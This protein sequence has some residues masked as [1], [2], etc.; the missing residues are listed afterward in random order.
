MTTVSN[1]TATRNASRTPASSA[2]VAD[3]L[4][5]HHMLGR[6]ARGTEV[7][8]LQNL[9]KQNGID[10]GP[11]D[12]IFGPKTQAAVRQFQQKKGLQVDGKVGQQTWAAL[13]G[14]SAA[15]GTSML[16]KSAP[17]GS[18]DGVDAPR[19]KSTSTSGSSGT[20]GGVPPDLKK[21]GNGRIPRSALS[22]IGVGNH[23]L[24]RPAAAAFQRMAA[25]ARKAGVNI[26][27]TDSYRSYE[28]QVDVARRK[29][30]Y[31]NGG[32]AATPGTSKHGW[33]LAVDVDVNSKGLNWLRENA[34]KY[35]F[36]TIPREP[37]HWQYGG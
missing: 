2:S 9:L 23:R 3:T 16:A 32:L 29:G 7:K 31:K 15:P 30:L 24:A 33:G 22:P 28:A 37:W 35:G 21:Y 14:M 10:P 8:E 13:H 20:S 18:G 4:K 11:S 19:P 26:G 17:T 5:T 1:A 34:S 12:G 27:V 36:S 25:D 6:G